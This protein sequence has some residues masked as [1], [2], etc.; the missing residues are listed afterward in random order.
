MNRGLQEGQT[1]FLQSVYAIYKAYLTQELPAKI[2]FEKMMKADPKAGLC[3]L[4]YSLLQSFSLEEQESNKAKGVKFLKE[5][6][7]QGFS[8]ASDLLKHVE[9]TARP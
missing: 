7:K 1:A 6:S 8:L 2:A 5:A 3:M 4:G 9:I